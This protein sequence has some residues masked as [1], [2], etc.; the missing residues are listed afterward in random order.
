MILT[1]FGDDMWLLTTLLLWVPV[2]GEVVNATK[3]VITLQ[4]PWVSIFQ[5]ENVTL[6]CEGPHLPGDSSTQWFIN[7]TAVQISTPSYSIPEAS[8]QDS[9]EYRCQIGSS[10]PSDPVQLQIH[11]DWLLLQASR[12]VLTEGEPL[13]LRCHG[14]KNKLVYNVVFYRNGKSFQFSSDSEVAILKTNLSHSGIY[15]C[16][17][18]GRHRY[19]S[20]GVSITVK[21]LFTTPVL[22]ASVSSPFPEG[23]LVTLNCETNLLLQRPGLQLHFSFY[24]GSKILEYRNTSSEYHIPRVERED[25]GFY[26]CEV[27]TEDSSVLKRS[28]ELELQ[29]LGP[30]SSAPVWFHILFYLSVGIM[31]SL[32]TVLY[33]KIHR[34]QREKKYNLEVPLVSEQGKKAN[35]FQQVRSDGVYEEVTATA[36]QTT[37]KEAPDGPRS[38][39]GDCGPEQPEPLPPS[40]STGAQTSQS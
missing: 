15:H 2:G 8:F 26:W 11:N 24:V 12:R 19:T 38:S 36:S 6:W 1:S 23:S 14:W 39:V 32:N 3:V 35:S 33:V 21:E 27:A 4:P 16:S 37:P 34:L 7:G 5:K 20:A 28:P 22:R 18:T 40:D 10:M 29:V 25:A 13:A 9:G 17:G 31:F 30:Q